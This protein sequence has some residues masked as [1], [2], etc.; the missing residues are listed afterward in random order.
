MYFVDPDGMQSYDWFEDEDGYHF[1]PNLTADNASTILTNGEIYKG[2][3]FTENGFFGDENGNLFNSE[4]GEL[5]ERFDGELDEIVLVSN[6]EDKGYKYNGIEYENETDLYFGILI[7]QAAKQFG[8]KDILALGA[9]LSGYNIIPTRG[10][11]EGA[12][13][14]TSL[15]SKLSRNITLSVKKASLG[16]LTKLPTLTGGP[17][18]GAP[19]RKMM[20]NT[21]GKFLGRTLGPIGWGILVYDVG[22]TLYNTQQ[23][24]NSI[25]NGN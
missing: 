6:S 24:Y 5:I 3:S 16:T 9:G 20:V 19:L 10:K 14:G 8:I 17:F 2:A 25:T 4:T 18:T 15:N 13:K 7:D 12:I 1:D 23:I 21:I 22:M 11:F